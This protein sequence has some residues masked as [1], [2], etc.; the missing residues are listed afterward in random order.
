MVRTKRVWLGVAAATAFMLDIGAASVTRAQG[1]EEIVVTARKREE[2]L[3]SVPLAI[4]AFT[5]DDL[6]KRVA[7]DM[8]DIS[9]LTPGFN[10]ED[11]GGFGAT[12]PVIRGATQ[13]AGSTEQPVSF[14]LDGV[15][16]PRSYVT[17]IGFAGIERIE[18]VKGPQSARY[19]RNAFMGAVNYVTKKPTDEWKIDAQGTWGNGQR[20]DGELTV[21]GPIVKERLSVLGGVYRSVYD[22]SWKNP[23]PF[24]N[25]YISPGTDCSLGGYKKTT[26]NFAVHITPTDKL[27]IDL[28]SF[29]FKSKREQGAAT[30]FQE[31]DANSGVLNCGQYNP[32]VRPA[33]SGLGGGGQWFRLYCGQ[34]PL[35]VNAV[36]P[37]GYGSQLNADFRRVAIGYD[38]TDAL[39]VEYVYGRVQASNLSATYGDVIPGCTYFIDPNGCVISGAGYSINRTESHDARLS[40]DDKGTIRASVGIL[41][42]PTRDLTQSF[43]GSIPGPLT[44]VPVKPIDPRNPGDFN[45]GLY[46]I[47]GQN[48]TKNEITSPF[49]EV[50]VSLMDNRLRVGAEGR[51]TH[52]KRYQQAF[53]S[54]GGGQ[55][56]G[57]TGAAYNATY[58]YFTPRFTVDYDLTS[59]NLI[60]ASA[61][62]GVKS[63]GFNTSAFRAEN[64]IYKADTNWTYEVGSKNTFGNFRLNVDVFL[65]KWSNMQVPA[66]DPGNPAALPIVIT[67]NLGNLTSKGVEA[68]AAYA[69][70]ENFTVNGTAYYGSPT[71]DTGTYDLNFARTPAI[72]DN[73]VC[74]T[75]G[76]IGGK[77][78][79]RSS[80]F[81]G[82]F[83]A[84]FQGDL[85]VV[86]NM[87]YYVRGDLAYQSKAYSDVMNLAWAQARTLVNASAGITT[88]NYELQ[89]WVRNLFDKKYVAV[90]N[91]TQPNVGY[92]GAIGDQ[93]TLGLTVRVKY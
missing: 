40:W 70:S 93:R 44:S 54:P 73:R 55:L 51:F 15:Y 74:P 11:F 12:A 50:S 49:G 32:N 19:G 83:G 88:D 85:S 64:R 78:T 57:I 24:C 38:L 28:T 29:N 3:Q 53:S 91:I 58:N 62:R 26:Y 14:F 41:Y 65:A 34:L 52:E 72:C 84:E 17:D 66:A 43:F 46:F 8:R 36:D 48:L 5:S 59:T 92:Y 39:R 79:P 13:I 18:V 47:L 89:F 9:A 25:S 22:G 37:R 20:L 2:L 42:A 77:T 76:Y 86:Q 23:H 75:N 35:T 45:P 69:F 68:E 63:G 61:A 90:A 7:R 67:L 4:T 80:K 60:Y 27:T 81:M 21:S 1:L 87:R 16:L 31:L 10:F 6:T 71:Y 82:T 30:Y 33:G 56:A